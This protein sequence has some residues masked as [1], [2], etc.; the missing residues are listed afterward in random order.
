MNKIYP[1]AVGYLSQVLPLLADSMA[2]LQK[3]GQASANKFN[4]DPTD[5]TH[6]NAYV[7]LHPAAIIPPYRVYFPCRKGNIYFG[8]MVADEIKK[9]PALA[10][11]I[12]ADATLSGKIAA[13]VL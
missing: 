12:V 13:G 11:H 2:Y 4:A 8:R 3:L 9:V 6:L 7:I 5:T 10:S 1:H